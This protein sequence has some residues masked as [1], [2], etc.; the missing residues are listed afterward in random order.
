MEND[1]VLAAIETECN[2]CLDFVLLTGNHILR[3]SGFGQD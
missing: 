3:T 1:K 2:T